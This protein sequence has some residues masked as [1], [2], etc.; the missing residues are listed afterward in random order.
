MSKKVKK[1]PS[2]LRSSKSHA[3]CLTVTATTSPVCFVREFTCSGEE[4]G[5]DFVDGNVDTRGVDKGMA[6]GVVT[7]ESSEEGKHTCLLT[8]IHRNLPCGGL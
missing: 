6:P 3:L 1:S 2:S 5:L 8:L 4:P 7:L